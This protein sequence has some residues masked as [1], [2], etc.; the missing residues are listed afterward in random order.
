MRS[1]T[2]LFAIILLLVACHGGQRPIDRNT[3]DQAEDGGGNGSI[4]LPVPS[5]NPPEETEFRQGVNLVCWYPSCY[6]AEEV[7]ATLD[8]LQDL[9]VEWLAIVP[10]WYQ[11]TLTSNMIFEDA[12]GSPGEADVRFIIERA[13]ARGMQVFLKPHV[14]VIAGGWRGN[15]TP[16]DP[17]DWRENYRTF[18][19]YFAGL[20][21]DLNVES[22]SIG[23]ELRNQSIDTVFW[24]NLVERVRQIY[25]G[26]LTYSANWDEYDSVDFW[27]ALD[28]IGIDFYFPLSDDFN[29]T[30][31]E[32]IG[33]LDRIGN[34]L[35]GFAASQLKAIVL[36]EI[37]YRS[38]DGAITRPYDFTWERPI[39]LGEQADAYAAV[40][41]AFSDAD[42]LAGI[43]WWRTDPRGLGGPGDNGYHFY[44][45]PAENILRRA[46]R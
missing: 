23:T 14:D 44:G 2:P 12:E 25:D 18:I 22:F 30:P 19:L 35:S 16:S 43:F 7:D 24:G 37:G 8:T 13:K 17:A 4:S 45:K 15:I 20:A 40:L 34:D 46:W 28:F 10:T 6:Q 41:T 27:G 21:Q 9:G 1:I 31:A 42:W 39:D 32:M 29:A 36:T 33:A 11:E 3:Q 26:A 5:E 38:I